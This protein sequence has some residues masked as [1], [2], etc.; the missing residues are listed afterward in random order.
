MHWCAYF[1]NQKEKYWNY[2][3][4]EEGKSHPAPHDPLEE[5]AP[6]QIIPKS[7]AASVKVEESVSDTENSPP[8]RQRRLSALRAAA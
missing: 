7:A 8:R 6:E 1:F 3:V 4:D 2:K 5:A